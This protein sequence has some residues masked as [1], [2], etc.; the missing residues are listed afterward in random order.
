MSV[1]KLLPTFDVEKLTQ[2]WVNYFVQKRYSPINLTRP[3]ILADNE[4]LSYG[5]E[6][7]YDYK[8]Q[9]YVISQSDY[10]SPMDFIRGTY[11]ETVIKDVVSF[12]SQY[13]HS[14]GRVRLIEL[15]P[16]QCLT[17]HN[18]NDSIVRYH[19]P[20]ITN[21]RVMFI[22]EDQVYRM[23]EVGR[24]YSLDVRKNH[25]VLNASREMRL[26]LVLDGYQ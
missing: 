10:N 12:A 25:T 8:Q 7:L 20:I 13:N 14:I 9:K 21:S 19:I 11:T 6:S 16:K 1:I 2:E 3:S 5:A 22:V 23:S 26:H 18:D 24:L 17:Y 4:A 15:R